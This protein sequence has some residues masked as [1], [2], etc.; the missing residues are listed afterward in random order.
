M[1]QF[2]LSVQDRPVSLYLLDCFGDHFSAEKAPK[3]LKLGK[4]HLLRSDVGYAHRLRAFRASQIVRIY[5]TR[6]CP[7][8]LRIT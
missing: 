6:H 5:M 3:A 4:P 2:S 7:I 1:I 8:F